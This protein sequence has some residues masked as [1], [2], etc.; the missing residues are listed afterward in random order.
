VRTFTSVLVL[1]IIAANVIAYL[2]GGF[3][4]IAKWWRS[5]LAGA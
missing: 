1:L 5:K 4:G 3:P 2:N